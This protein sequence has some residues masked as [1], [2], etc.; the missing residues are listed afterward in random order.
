MRNNDFKCLKSTKK[1]VIVTHE[2]ET[3]EKR[4]HNIALL[5][6]LNDVLAFQRKHDHQLCD[7]ICQL[8]DTCIVKAEE[9]IKDINI[10]KDRMSCV[11]TLHLLC[12]SA[13]DSI[14]LYKKR[15]GCFSVR[16]EE[17]IFEECTHKMKVIEAET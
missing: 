1:V 2:A 5:G 12:I 9:I 8:W 7:D 13:A 4:L 10:D 11:L 14:K 6:K 16:V 15:R 3:V 17:N